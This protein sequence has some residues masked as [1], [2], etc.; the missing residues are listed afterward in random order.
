MAA[1]ENLQPFFFDTL[2]KL[3][4]AVVIVRIKSEVLPWEGI[5]GEL[6]R[7][8]Q[9]IQAGYF[10]SSCSIEGAKL[11][12]FYVGRVSLAKAMQAIKTAIDMRGLLPM[13][14]LLHAETTSA[15]REWYPGNPAALIQADAGTN[16]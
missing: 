11:Y 8:L 12:F 3:K 1:A 14:T 10:A 6:G 9:S 5:E 7:E 16:G 15:L 13:T 2:T 4:L